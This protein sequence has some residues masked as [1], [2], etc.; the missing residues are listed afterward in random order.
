MIYISIPEG[1]IFDNT[2][3]EFDVLV[4]NSAE[5]IK[6]ILLQHL[7]KECLRNK[8]RH[9]DSFTFD[10]KETHNETITVYFKRPPNTEAS[11]IQYVPN[12]NGKIK[13]ENPCIVK[14]F[15]AQGIK[16]AHTVGLLWFQ[17]PTNKERLTSERFAEIEQHSAE[18]KEN[19]RHT[20]NS[21]L[22]T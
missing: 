4:N 10:P 2:N 8:K 22:P 11:F 5:D 13:S 6:H 16:L 12:Q 1:W 20:G 18:Q 21:P 15:E 14:G 17:I 7:I 19:R 3:Y 9:T